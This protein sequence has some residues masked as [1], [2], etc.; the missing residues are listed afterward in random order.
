MSLPQSEV[1]I[2]KFERVV[3]S[4]AVP[5]GYTLAWVEPGKEKRSQGWKHF[6]TL[7]GA[8]LALI[9]PRIDGGGWYNYRL[10]DETSMMEGI[11]SELPACRVIEEGAAD[12]ETAITAGGEIL[13]AFLS[14]FVGYP[15]CV[16]ASSGEHWIPS[17]YADFKSFSRNSLTGPFRST[18]AKERH[19][20]Q[21]IARTSLVRYDQGWRRTQEMEQAARREGAVVKE[22]SYL[23]HFRYWDVLTNEGEVR[24]HGI[25]RFRPT[26]T[27]QWEEPEVKV[28]D[29]VRYVAEGQ[30][31]RKSETYEGEEFE[32]G[33]T[34]AVVRLEQD[35]E[36]ARYVAEKY[37]E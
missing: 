24:I 3:H 11:C 15:E 22:G 6:I 4:V 25:A 28:I 14:G 7:L 18:Q 17:I 29:G 31:D 8:D 23:I 5:T 36:I 35:I 33:V 27:V 34:F 1:D 21:A 26:L 12:I 9:P 37:G 13:R 19:N 16:L 32:I 30:K 2:P 20:T 10:T